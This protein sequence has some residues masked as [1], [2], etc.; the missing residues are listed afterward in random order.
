MSLQNKCPECGQSIP[1]DHPGGFCAHCLLALGLGKAEAPPLAEALPDELSLPEVKAT[2]KI[3]GSRWDK[4]AD[5]LPSEKAGDWIGP[6]HLLQEIGRG[7]CGVVYMAEQTEPV[8]RKVALKVIKLGM[9]TR[10][11]VARFEAERHALAL[12]DHPNIAKVLDAGATSTGRPYFVMELVGGVKITDYCDRHQLTARERLNLFIPVCRAIQHAHQK[13]IIHRDIKPSNV[14]V[15]LQDG[16]AVPKVIDFGIAKAT[17]GRLTDQTLFT[18]F[19]QFIGTP[20]YMSPEQAQLGGL[21][22]DTRSDIYSLGVLLYE[23]LTGRTPFDAKELIGSGLEAMRRTICEK[24]P[25]R[26]STRLNREIAGKDSNKEQLSGVTAAET[27]TP[28]RPAQLFQS[29]EFIELLQGDLDWIVMKC[30]EKDRARR[31]ETA[32]GLATDLQ[33]H[34]NQEPVLARPPSTIYQ[35]QKFVRRHRLAVG[36]AVAI[37]LVLLLGIAISTWQAIRATKAERTQARLLTEVEKAKQAATEKLWSAYLAEARARRVSGQ[38][39]QRFESLRAIRA[40]T[41]IRPSPELRDE[42]IAS[43]VLADIEL[44]GRKDFNQARSQAGTGGNQQYYA[45]GDSNNIVRL[46]RVADDRELASHSFAG[47]IDGIGIF[48][49]DSRVV[50]VYV[51]QHCFFW[52][53]ENNVMITPVHKNPMGYYFTPDGN[54]LATSDPTNIVLQNLSDGTT[55]A[56]ISLVGLSLPPKTGWYRF[57]PALKRVAFY[58]GANTN[59]FI[60]DVATGHTLATLSHPSFLYTLSWHLEGRYLATI[61]DAFVFIWDSLSGKV[62]KKI[63]FESPVSLAFNHQGNLLAVSGWDSQTHLLEFPSGRELVSIYASGNIVGFAPDDRRL[64]TQGWDGNSLGFFEINSGFGLKTLYENL[65]RTEYG[66]G[67]LVYSSDGRLLAFAVF[68]G[69]RVSDTRDNLE[70]GIVGG[71]GASPSGFD[72][73]DKHL[74]VLNAQENWR[75]DVLSNVTNDLLSLGQPT[76]ESTGLPIV[77]LT[78][79]GSIAVGYRDGCWVVVR[80]DNFQELARTGPVIQRDGI[81]ISP[82]G[83]FLACNAWHHPGIKVWDAKT[84]K[85][86]KELPADDGHS[87]TA[88][89]VYF[90]PDSRQLAI[91]TRDE[92]SFYDTT[93][94][95][96]VRRIAQEPGNDFPGFTAFSHDGKLFAGV[97]TRKMVRLYDTETG[98]V[99]ADLKAPGNGITGLSFNPAVTQL[100]QV[101]SRQAVRAWDLKAIRE[102]LAEMRLDWEMPRYPTSTGITNIASPATA[103]AKAGNR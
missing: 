76:M 3:P 68:G 94:W 63:P 34:L 78:A 42:A 31:Y 51:G 71:D 16:V 11:V 85:L 46:R 74:L 100:L 87:D 69:V 91:S 6:Y 13:G 17:Q 66:G 19:E 77:E 8:R 54:C 40:A 44:V 30:L 18:A 32:T 41:A 62:A 49:P 80:S 57:D 4:I 9:D 15:A 88:A 27:D 96:C 95:Q 102:Q 12:M 56:S 65:E 14:L 29:Q 52:N 79:D 59:V 23:L 10:Q 97:H 43:L 26:P 67:P 1:A 60:L 75:Y 37:T 82:D 22:V 89:F 55:T 33:R 90:S 20:A 70:L 101:E 84:G 2:E 86:L 61:S 7:G 81:T 28:A 48:S 25:P 35:A 38:S 103:P 47:R 53:W 24:E 83:R 50:P 93:T 21:D 73:K 58:P 64:A 99:L 92:F 72:A 98:K 5:G 39:G 36:S 45:V